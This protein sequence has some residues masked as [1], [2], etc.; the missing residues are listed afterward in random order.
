[1][2]DPPLLILVTGAY[3]S[4]K[5]TL[6]RRVGERLGIPVVSRDD[7]YGGLMATLG[8]PDQEPGGTWSRR[9]VESFYSLVRHY[10]DAGVSVIAEQGFRAGIAEPDLL[11]LVR[12]AQARLLRAE[13]PH[14]VSVRRFEERTLREARARSWRADRYVLER[15]R[16]GEV[17]WARFEIPL[18]LGDV[19]VLRVDASDGYEPTLE[20]IADFAIR[21]RRQ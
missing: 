9:G 10:L 16:A 18:S 1:M 13:V 21:G 4:G 8:F 6:A 19:P 5:T 17:D 2:S 14:E 7:V 12:M 15:M 20:E 11:P 3:A